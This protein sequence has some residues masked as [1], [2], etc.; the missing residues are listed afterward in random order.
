M[1]EATKA[2]P[3]KSKKVDGPKKCWENILGL[4]KTFPE[5]ESG[6]WGGDKNGWG[7]AFE[8][9]KWLYA[10]HKS[11]FALTS[12][13]EAEA[14]EGAALV[15]DEWLESTTLVNVA[16][17]GNREYVLLTAGLGIM[18]SG[19]L[20]IIGWPRRHPRW[21]EFAICGPNRRVVVLNPTVKQ[22]EDLCSG[23][24]IE[25]WEPEEPE[26]PEEEGGDA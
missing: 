14:V 26:E 25:L 4:L 3:K 9:I 6:K 13:L 18:D 17:T 21:W 11:Y 22:V 20:S 15:T 7:F 10:Q 1:T 23:L 12:A 16:G 24:N 8:F 19:Y 5:W 2:A